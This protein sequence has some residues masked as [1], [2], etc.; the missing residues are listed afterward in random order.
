M[1][2]FHSEPVSAFFFTGS[3]RRDLVTPH[4]AHDAVGRTHH[5]WSS[6]VAASCAIQVVPAV[7]IAGVAGVLVSGSAV[8]AVGVGAGFTL[9]RSRVGIEALSRTGRNAGVT[10]VVEEARLTQVARKGVVALLTVGETG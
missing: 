8:E 2:G 4:R 3:L 10:K 1:G 9:S 5:V 7:D 6:T